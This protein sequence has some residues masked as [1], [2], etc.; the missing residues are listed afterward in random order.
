MNIKNSYEELAISLCE[1]FFK[2][3][4]ASLLTNVEKKNV[5]QLDVTRER[6]LDSIKE[7]LADYVNDDGESLTDEE[8]EIVIELVRR[9]MWGYGTIDDLIHRKD[10]SDIKLYGPDNIRIKAYGKRT[11]SE[12]TFSDAHDYKRFINKILERCKVNLGTANAIQT[13]TD[14]SQ[15][16]FILRITV[17]SGLLVDT[18]LP[19]MAIRKIPKDKYTLKDLEDAGMFRHKAVKQAGRAIVACGAADFLTEENSDLNELMDK[20]I[21]SKGI[22]FTGKGASGKSTLMNAMIALI[23]WD[24]SVMICQENAELF[25]VKHPDL[26]SAHVMTNAGDSKV[27]YELG[28]LTRAALLVDLDRVIVG[29][30]KEGSEAAG[31]SKASMTGHKCWTSVHGE[32]CEMAVDKMADYISQATGYST[33]DSLKQL[34]GFEYVIHLRDFHVDEIIRIAGWDKEREQLIYEQIYPITKAGE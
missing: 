2:R 7:E 10:I 24:E 5:D 8:K 30:V 13:F 14:A 6:I 25:D 16:D 33:R 18:G 19:L 17:I 29:E 28:D 23:P 26:F 22:L 32:S 12:I 9:N 31:L 4:S 34:Q 15:D 11:G 3:Q 21:R 27:S 20:M 1:G